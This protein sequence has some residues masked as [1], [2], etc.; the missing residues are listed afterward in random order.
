MYCFHFLV[1]RHNSISRDDVAKELQAVLHQVAPFEVQA[2]VC[3]LQPEEDICQVLE[4][5]SFGLA[6]QGQSSDG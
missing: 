6:L 3:L 4:V 2:E 1:V 5:L